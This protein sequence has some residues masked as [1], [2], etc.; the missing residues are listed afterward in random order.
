[1]EA[2]LVKRAG[3][4]FV[5]VPAAG[6]HGVGWKALPGN[7]VQLAR[8]IA[9]ARRIV[10]GYQPD[11]ILLTGGYVGV[12][13]ALAAR[14]VPK[15]VYIPDLEPGQ[16]LRLMARLADTVAVSAS[17]VQARLPGGKR[18]VVTGYPTRPELQGIDRRSAK[19]HFQLEAS[20]STVLVFG[21]SKG[22][23]SIN[24]ALWASLADV[25]EFGQVIHI[26]GTLDWPRTGPYQRRLP[27]RL[28]GRYRA[29]AYLHEEMGMALAAAD[30]AV[31]RAGASTL[32]EL[33]LFGLPAVLVP[34]P[35]A[36]RYQRVNADYLAAHG[37]AVC[38]EDSDLGR[39]L[40]PTIHNLLSDPA[41]LEHMRTAMS[42]LA[43]PGA[44]AEIAAEVERL[45]GEKGRPG[46]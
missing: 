38:L 41:L 20:T 33:P 13:V 11:A 15:L 32:G 9:A 27:Q 8:G 10:A 29:F 12:P 37:G 6:L 1:M 31:A 18:T 43:R 25:L 44:A 30:L 7:L 26:T 36:W 5:T 3:V 45:V 24:E 16:A 19:A 40:L 35:Y 42:S 17:D 14:R 4:R 39:L 46:G 34:Y 21:G 23:R 28:A 2:P 22:A